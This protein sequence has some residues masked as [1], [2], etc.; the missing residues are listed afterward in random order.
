MLIVYHHI[1]HMKCSI[2]CDMK[3]RQVSILHRA[4]TPSK[5]TKKNIS[6]VDG[7]EMD[8]RMT[9]D[10]VVIVRHDRRVRLSNGRYYFVDRMTYAELTDLIGDDVVLFDD[11]LKKLERRGLL[12]QSSFI[13]DLDIKQ[14]GM[15]AHIG[16]ILNAYTIRAQVMACSVDV[17][18][19]RAFHTAYSDVDLCLTLEPMKDRWDIWENKTFK[20]ITAFLYFTLY[21]FI[22]RIIRRKTQ[23][24]DFHIFRLFRQ[25]PAKDDIA[26]ASIYYRLANSDI[27]QFLHDRNLKVF[28]YGA[29]TIHDYE[30]LLDDGVDGVKVKKIGKG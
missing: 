7:V 9:K 25:K 27:I 3:R 23:T 4:N 21:P 15:A 13:L 10:G 12:Y 26:Y 5:L 1:T 22:F 6:P 8:V 11:Q 24:G 16:K 29:D 18:H 20:I 14:A 28:V 30:S 19:L 17:V 2:L